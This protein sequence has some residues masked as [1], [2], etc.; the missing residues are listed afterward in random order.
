MV[1]LLKKYKYTFF[2]AQ[3]KLLILVISSY[4]WSLLTNGKHHELT[5]NTFTL[6]WKNTWFYVNQMAF[7]YLHSMVWFAN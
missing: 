6:Q 5:Q 2:A 3:R 4:K 1:I 7:R